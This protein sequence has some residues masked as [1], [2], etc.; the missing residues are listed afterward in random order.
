MLQFMKMDMD[1]LNNRA[2]S[3]EMYNNMVAFTNTKKKDRL[4]SASKEYYE[5]LYQMNEKTLGDA[6]DVDGNLQEEYMYTAEDRKRLRELRQ[7]MKEKGVPWYK[8][9]FYRQ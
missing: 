5:N 3:I 1:K 8:R 7:Q 6:I 4:M 2:S 9:F